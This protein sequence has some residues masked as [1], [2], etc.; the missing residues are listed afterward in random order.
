MAETETIG[1]N[2]SGDFAAE[3]AAAARAAEQLAGGLDKL[4]EAEKKQQTA[5]ADAG[6]AKQSISDQT[7]AHEA[8]AAKR[9]AADAQQMDKMA[10]GFAV[11]QAASGAAAKAVEGDWLSAATGILGMLGPE[12]AAA[13][14]ILGTMGAIKNAIAEV[15]EKVW[16][17]VSDYGKL[18][19]AS[20]F[21]ETS[22]REAIVGA[23]EGMGRS[24]A[25]A[26]AAYEKIAK[27]AIDTGRSKQAI[28]DE[29]RRLAGYGDKQAMEL[30]KAIDSTAAAIGDEKA[31]GLLEKLAKAQAKG[32]NQE[33]VEG[34]AEAGLKVDIVYRELAKQTGKS[35]DKV[36]ADL[37]AGKITA[38]QYAEAVKAAASQQFGN[39]AEK[40]AGSLL[41]LVARIKLAVLELFAFDEATVKPV[42]DG[43]KAVLA[44]IQGGGGAEIKTELQALA[45][46]IGETFGLVTEGSTVKDFFHS[47]AGAV[48][49]LRTEFDAMKPQ[50]KEV[51]ALLK[52]LASD[53]TLTNLAK[54]AAGAARAKLKEAKDATQSVSD[55]AGIFAKLKNAGLGDT[56][57]GAGSWLG[58]KLAWVGR[59]TDVFGVLKPSEGAP[60]ADAGSA[61]LPDLGDAAGNAKD[62]ALPVGDALDLGM[63]EGILAGI[64]GIESAAGLAAARA[65]A[66]AKQKLGVASPSE[67]FAKIGS[68]S[69]EGMAK[70]IAANES[71]ARAAGAMAGNA[72]GAA[73]G[74][75]AGAGA[76][77]SA[78]AGGGISITINL[79]AGA[80]PAQASA[81][82]AEIDKGLPGWL[83]MQR[84]AGRD[85]AEAA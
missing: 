52:Q 6:K 57:A 63:I 79:G 49:Q 71:P 19:I 2:L 55:Q 24:T 15:R 20:V 29:F 35:V 28:A 68:Y 60:K 4:T 13:A 77:G 23:L 46:D 64:P 39:A 59:K 44:E 18:G 3:A 10:K 25:E 22:Q 83:A 37:K 21:E 38:E 14:A 12:G 31:K 61:M 73:A 9:S 43:L 42:K 53:G 8:A 41:G 72:L 5:G 74:G 70:G 81:V 84:R 62:S 75:A 48:K 47:V 69:S 76:A 67:E 32:V 40:S 11:V 82:K 65:L 26:N 78:G 58:D 33:S 85:A 27:E 17:L 66:A 7:A 34:L 1:L 50:I 16:G 36:K 56:A 45:L 54:G 51:I 80:T 30:T